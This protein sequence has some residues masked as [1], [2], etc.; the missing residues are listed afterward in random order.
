MRTSRAGASDGNFALD[1]DDV[2]RT[3]YLNYKSAPGPTRA[4]VDA[5]SDG[6][7]RVVS[8]T[9]SPP[10]LVIKPIEILGRRFGHRLS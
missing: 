2:H 5:A 9:P 3:I 1:G 8:V 7:N 4:I 10:R 6:R